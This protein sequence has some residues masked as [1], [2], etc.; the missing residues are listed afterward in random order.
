VGWALTRPSSISGTK[1]AGWLIIFFIEYH[2]LCGIKITHAAA[3]LGSCRHIFIFTLNSKTLC[4]ITAWEVSAVGDRKKKKD[5][6]L[7]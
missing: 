7:M 6:T 2:L 5:D 4:Y 3:L 1:S